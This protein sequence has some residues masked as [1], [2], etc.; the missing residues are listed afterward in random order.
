MVDLK[1]LGIC[2]MIIGVVNLIRVLS[3]MD[4][5]DLEIL[6]NYFSHHIIF[7][8]FLW[9]LSLIY[10]YIIKHNKDA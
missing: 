10:D 7:E 3:D 5:M 4:Y 1:I 8:I 9:P 6:I 2:Y